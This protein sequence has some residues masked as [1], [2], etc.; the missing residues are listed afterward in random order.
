MPEA[1]VSVIVALL[2]REDVLAAAVTFSVPFP[3]VPVFDRVS[4]V[5]DAGFVACQDVFAP[6]ETGKVPPGPSNESAVGESVA[7]SA[8]R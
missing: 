1:A 5:A 6:T 7:K 2:A 8:L 4:H 3:S